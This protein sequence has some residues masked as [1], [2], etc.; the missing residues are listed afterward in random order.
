[1]R[2]GVVV[3]P[4]SN[5][6]LDV[7]HVV[8]DVLGWSTRILWHAETSLVGLDLVVLPGGFSYGDYLR[9]GALA[10]YS[11]IMAAI[12]NFASKGG[13][14]LGI[15]NGFQILLEAGMLEGALMQNRQIRF[16][17]KP[18][19]VRVDSTKSFLTASARKGQVSSLPIAPHCG[20]YYPTKEALTGLNDSGRILFRY[21]S[22]DGTQDDAFNPN[23]SIEAIAGVSN[24]EGNVVGLMPH[25][26]RAAERLLG[27]EDGLVLFR[28]V[29]SWIS[30]AS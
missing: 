29:L 14:V 17:C 20:S 30:Q 15:C 4:G 28:G 3:F 12:K 23:G 19:C 13:L 18:T 22:S 10:S 1:M 26:E 2:V 25:P 8:Q 16:V 6:D 11:P 7:V 9:P 27:S 24:E 5:C 21:V